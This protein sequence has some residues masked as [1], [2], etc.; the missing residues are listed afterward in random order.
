VCHVGVP[1]GCAT[2]VC[3]VGVAREYLNCYYK[4]YPTVTY[5][6]CEVGMISIRPS[7]MYTYDVK[8]KWARPFTYNLMPLYSLNQYYYYIT[9]GGKHHSGLQLPDWRMV[10]LCR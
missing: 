4:N 9:G 10:P 2:W 3:H 6:T 1:R 7:Y 5:E 8:C